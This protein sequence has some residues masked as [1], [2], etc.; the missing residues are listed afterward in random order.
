LHIS[1]ASI[2]CSPENFP[3]L[4][5]VLQLSHK[6]DIPNLQTVTLNHLLAAYP[7]T[8]S[9]WDA[10]ESYTFPLSV[11]RDRLKTLRSQRPHPLVIVSLALRVRA[12]PLLVPAYL[13]LARLPVSEI[14]RGYTLFPLLAPTQNAS[15]NDD[16]TACPNIPPSYPTLHLP[17]LQTAA[18]LRG[19]ETLQRFIADF[20]KASIEN[21]VQSPLCRYFQPQ[22]PDDPPVTV[23]YPC[24]A[25]FVRIS[26]ELL[27][28]TAGVSE[29]VDSDPL[30]VLRC[31]V[32]MLKCTADFDGNGTMLG[33]QISQKADDG[34]SDRDVSGDG[35]PGINGGEYTKDEACVACTESFKQTVDA[36]R[37][38]VWNCLPKW[39]DLRKLIEE[40]FEE[41]WE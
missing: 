6:Y 15:S 32:E 23:Q 9:E 5:S 34:G 19:K 14:I 37:N 8:L 31:A 38:H 35:V 17:T 39:F 29:G 20:I 28:M 24:A 22:V 30:F 12:P 7:L 1:R 25:A 33:A 16:A 11:R 2:N 27:V 4:A 41:G 40:G 3:L 21:H 10:R 13:D 26:H 18:V 36:A